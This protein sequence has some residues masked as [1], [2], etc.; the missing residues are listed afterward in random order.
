MTSKMV[1]SNH[2]C[3]F[4]R[5]VLE[6]APLTVRERFRRSLLRL[7]QRGIRNYK[8][9]LRSV[10]GLPEAQLRTAIEVLGQVGKKVAVP[11]LLAMLHTQPKLRFEIRTALTSIGGKRAYDGLVQILNDKTQLYETRLEACYGLAHQWRKLDPSVFFPIVMDETNDSHLRGQAVEG[12]ATHGQ[13]CDR[14]KRGRRLAAEVLLGCLADSAAEVRFWGVF[15]V[16]C[17]KAKESLPKLWK[18]ARSDHALASLGW[19][20]AEE[21]KD[22]IHYLTKGSLPD[23]DASERRSRASLSQPKIAQLYN[24]SV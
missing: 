7:Q 12:I 2:L 16:M 20:V 18:L 23:L 19:S 5:Q 3:R 6:A 15:G 24:E 21:A 17:F 4:F 9:L 22:A 8:T 11:Q 13:Y 10:D 14:R 1:S